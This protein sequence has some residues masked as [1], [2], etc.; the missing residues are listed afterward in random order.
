MSEHEHQRWTIATIGLLV[1]WSLT[2][3]GCVWAVSADHTQVSAK[4]QVHQLRVDDHEARLRELE[5]QTGAIAADVRWIR[6][7]LEN[8]K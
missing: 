6:Q 3:I 7:D 8:R 5:K 4:L 2:V 1:S